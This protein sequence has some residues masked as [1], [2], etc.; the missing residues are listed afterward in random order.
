MWSTGYVEMHK[1]N[2]D[3]LKTL[4]ACV[5]II[6][7]GVLITALLISQRQ[8][9]AH[10]PIEE[11]QL[12]VQAESVRFE[13]ARV[14]IT[15]YGEVR[16][17]NVTNV[18]A[19]IAG[20][21]VA[22]HPRLEA[23]EIIPKGEVLLE[24]DPRDYQA[25]VDEIQARIQ[26]LQITVDRLKKQHASETDRLETFERSRDLA[27]TE[28]E[29]AQRLFAK[30]NI[31]SQSLV[32]AKEVAYNTAKDQFAQFA[33]T[34]EL[35]PL[36][37]LEAGSNLRAAEATLDKAEADLERTVISVP[38]DVRVKTVSLELHQYVLP[39]DVLMSLADDSVLDITVPI[40]SREARRWLL[41]DEKK[42]PDERAW[43]NELTQVPVEI[44][45]TE[46]VDEHRWRGRLHRV[47]RFDQQTRTLVVVVRV[48]AADAVSP[49][50]G[51]L[52][53]VEGM[54]VRVVIPGRTVE[55]VVKLPAEAVSF[56]REAS[57][58]RTV[59][60]AVKN[61][62]TG[63]IRLKSRPVKESHIAGDFVYLSKGLDEGDLV[64]TTRLI[65][66]LENTL[67]DLED[68]PHRETD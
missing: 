15:G 66:P 6:L 14:D 36:R 65:N 5:A 39:S 67:L 59:Y 37:I 43:F 8:A 2:L 9:P 30:E 47:E 23:G 53:L 21:V 60:L 45:W 1:P 68:P 54:F 17:R 56:D 28:F 31:E 12:R 44:A 13:D 48:T 49:H 25:R 19:G 58:Y 26:Q 10:A 34:L 32:D 40:N 7:V 27:K 38:M 33:Q 18:S 46:A 29:R 4:I 24:I 55:R 20:K 52:P 35:F 41:F 62:E 16:A 22:I 63:E 61:P 42:S 57:G 64:I 51:N 50:A 3:R 11:R